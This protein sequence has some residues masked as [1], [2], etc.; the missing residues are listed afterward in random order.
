MEL[1]VRIGVDFGKLASKMPKLM[2][3][4]VSKVA[5]RAAERAVEVIDSGKLTPIKDSTR[6]L[7]SRT[8]GNRPSTS[9]LKPLVHTGNLRNSIKQ[10]GN[11][12]RMAGYGAIHLQAHRTAGNS[13]IPN[14]HVPAR[15]FL[16]QAIKLGRTD[17]SKL[18]KVFIK[19]MKKALI[20]K[21]PLVLKGRLN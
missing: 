18:F 15:N 20:R 1:E 21:P 5:K 11:R 6:D 14:K 13:M 2:E 16:S 19:S 12:V 8:I 4:H 17:T 3:Q 7:R 9:S 10:V